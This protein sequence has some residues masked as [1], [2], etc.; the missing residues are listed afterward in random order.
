MR[1]IKCFL[2]FSVLWI[3]LV[4][5]TSCKNQTV[6]TSD[7]ATT[8]IDVIDKYV[9][10]TGDTD[11]YIHM[12]ERMDE[13]LITNFLYPDNE[14]YNEGYEDG[15]NDAEEK[16]SERYNEGYADG[17]YDADVPC[18]I[19]GKRVYI[20]D[21]WLGWIDK[22]SKYKDILEQINQAHDKCVKNKYGNN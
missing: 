16:A 13:T 12:L 14:K 6:I 2:V 10:Q 21:K 11:V 17:Q 18:Q 22:N 15:Y 5:S 20:E 3:L 4:G 1:F 8:Y 9:Q 19:C 7:E